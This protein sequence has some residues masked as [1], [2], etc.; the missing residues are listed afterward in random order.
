MENV[1]DSR[2]PRIWE[3]GNAHPTGVYGMRRK[4]DDASHQILLAMLPSKDRRLSVAV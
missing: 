4:I 2:A 1:P 3:P